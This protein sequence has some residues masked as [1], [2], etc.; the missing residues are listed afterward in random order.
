M[1]KDTCGNNQNSSPF[2]DYNSV[3]DEVIK[4]GFDGIYLDWVEG[5]E[6]NAVIRAANNQGKDA[7]VEMINF[8]EEMK[9]YAANRTTLFFII[10][11]NG[12]ALANGH[13]ELFS[14]IDGIAQEG[15]WYE[16]DATD[17]WNDPDGYDWEVPAGW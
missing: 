8:I 1:G 12:S 9:D 4:D 15:I 7:K 11:Q 10:Q 2:G 14:I 17:N 13:P 5:F 3:I 16:G 6:N